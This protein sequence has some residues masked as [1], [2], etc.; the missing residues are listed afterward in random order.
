MQIFFENL[1]NKIR[2]RASYMI[3]MMLLRYLKEYKF[4]NK[5]D[6]FYQNW[7]EFR[8]CIEYEISFTSVKGIEKKC[9]Q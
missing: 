9:V 5:V 6:F 7:F 1:L 8:K 4:F 3:F 2:K